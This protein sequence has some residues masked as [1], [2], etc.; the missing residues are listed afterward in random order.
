MQ[1]QARDQRVREWLSTG[2][3][4]PATLKGHYIRRHIAAE[5]ESRCAICHAPDEWQG[6]PL[7]LILD[8]I[9]GNADN[10]QRQNLRLICPNCDSQLATF[11]SRNRGNGRHG[12]RRRYAAGQS[13]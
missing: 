9:D 5:Q 4:N 7:T 12:R 2:I 10:N 1:D 11:K 6:Q 13:Y 3:G 8:H